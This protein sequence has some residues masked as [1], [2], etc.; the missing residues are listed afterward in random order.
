MTS[1]QLSDD[2][3]LNASSFQFPDDYERN[4]QDYEI[5]SVKVP[6]KFD[7]SALD[8]TTMQFNLPQE[9]DAKGLDPVVLTLESNGEKYSLCAAPL[10]ET[11][12]CRILVRNEDDENKE[13]KPSQNQFQNHF[14]LIQTT[15]TN[16]TDI[17]LAP[18]NERLPAVDTEKVPLKIP[19]VPIP[20]K[21]GLKRRWNVMGS[22][23]K[24]TPPPPPAMIEE[25]G[26]CS[27][28]D[29][30]TSPVKKAKG[31]TTP[32]KSKDKSS[33]KSPKKEKKTEKKSKK[34]KKK[35]K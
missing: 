23:A 29:P 5:W 32:K 33:E 11:S 30:S 10:E 35:V 28:V 14:C 1:Q 20:Q 17:D 31:E 22:S 2:S 13:M 4:P 3:L 12:T 6:V 19:Y 8:G 26:H 15:H 16:I 18:S 27:M 24:W 21:S 9:H 34:D 25:K 7:M